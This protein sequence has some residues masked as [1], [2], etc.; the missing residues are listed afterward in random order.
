M[1]RF[2]A[3]GF[4]HE[5]NT[6]SPIPTT[7]ESFARRNGPLTGI[8]ETDEL[9]DFLQQSRGEPINLATVGFNAVIAPLGHT[10]VPLIFAETEPSA[11][12]PAEVY[13]RIVG[14][15]TTRL[16]AKGPFDGVFL[17]LHGA[18]V[19]T[20]FNDGEEE[21]VRRV[22]AVVG[23]IPV[24]ASFDLHGNITAGCV[25]L[26]SALVGCRTYPHIDMYE[27]GERCAHLMLHLLAGEPLYTAFRAVPFL[28]PVSA[29][30]TF[31]EPC[32]S[33]YAGIDLI[34]A[35]PGVL[36]AT[37]MAGFQSADV[38]HQ[39]PTV[40]TYARSQAAAD[41]A[42]DRLL[43]QILA[44][45]GEFRSDLPDGPQAV[46]QAVKLA[47]S[48]D[49]PVILA[50]GCDN[51]GGGGTSDTVGILR[52]LL[53][54]GV[55]DAAIAMIYDPETAAQA[56]SAGP[57]AWIDAAV[58]GKRM[59]GQEPVRGRCLVEGLH[60]GVFYG[61]GKTSQGIPYNLGK[62]AHLNLNGVHIVVSSVR[63]QARDRQQFEVVGIQPETMKILVVKSA[64]HYR[65]DFEP[66]AGTIITVSDDGASIENPE[67]AVYK[68]LRK[69]VRLQGLGRES[70][71]PL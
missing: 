13:D 19:Y 27:T 12:I 58:G 29:Q 1:A 23:D 65:A 69:G 67:K 56:F 50:D 54:Q 61:R 39:G 34:E 43:E 46:S 42:A 52:A 38:Y 63:T 40:F 17:D 15:I 5:T 16:A 57:G 36:S 45:E 53:D 31:I 68:N 14:M 24:V 6:F 20:D 59:P 9:L 70:T 22:R 49:K 11:Q 7:Y 51:P 4:A 21:I 66:I 2:A 32:K 18:M 10:V 62:M 41:E 64:N 48:L 37:I 35:R 25:E 30:S 55:Q 44:R 28:W 26:A 71:G 3:A 60:E 8:L 47:Q 33:L